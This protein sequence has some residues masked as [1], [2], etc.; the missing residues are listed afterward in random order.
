MLASEFD[1]SSRVRKFTVTDD[2]RFRS[3]K[4]SKYDTYSRKTNDCNNTT[5][6]KNSDISRT[7]AISAFMVLCAESR[8]TGVAEFQAQR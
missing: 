6:S 7:T 1:Q 3:T 2:P 5:L 8:I 4:Y